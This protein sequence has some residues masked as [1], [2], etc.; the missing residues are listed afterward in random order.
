MPCW[1]SQKITMLDIRLHFSVW[2]LCVIIFNHQVQVFFGP[3]PGLCWKKTV[4]FLNRP[5]LY[6][7]CLDSQE[8]CMSFSGSFLGCTLS[9]WLLPIYYFNQYL[10]YLYFFEWITIF[11][12]PNTLPN[13]LIPKLIYTLLPCFVS[14]GKDYC[15]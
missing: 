7:V 5:N 14:S 13:L 10:G 11:L 15:W 4:F 9:Y 2:K 1:D 6:T 8:Y 12:F 3:P